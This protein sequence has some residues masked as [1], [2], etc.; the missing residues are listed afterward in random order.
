MKHL[1]VSQTN[2]HPVRQNV[3]RAQGVASWHADLCPRGS[4]LALCPPGIKAMLKYSAVWM[5]S[6][7]DESNWPN[8]KEALGCCN[9]PNWSKEQS[10]DVD[11]DLVQSQLQ[12][13]LPGGCS[14]GRSTAPIA[15]TMFDALAHRAYF[16]SFACLHSE[17][18]ALFF[19]CCFQWTTLRGQPIQYCSSSIYATAPLVSFV[20]SFS[21]DVDVFKETIRKA[22]KSV[23]M[24][25]FAFE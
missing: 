14:I 5:S 1:S 17:T 11:K 25:S 15:D 9:Q 12:K 8:Q 10:I 3:T 7:S 21:V 6:R 24:A 18:V 19:A 22:Q 16:T 20:Q 13:E 23:R 4:K 2:D